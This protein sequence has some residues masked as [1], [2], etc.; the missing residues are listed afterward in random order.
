MGMDVVILSPETEEFL[1][2]LDGLSNNSLIHRNEVSILLE[3]SGRHDRKT[4]LAELAFGAKFCWNL[5]SVMKRIGPGAKGYEHLMSEYN[6]NV[7]KVISS[8]KGLL[9]PSPDEVRKQFEEK[10]FINTQTSLQ[11]QIE[12]F[13]DISWIKNWSIDHKSDTPA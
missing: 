5:F 11:A 12:L 3:L 6:E 9:G 10:F 1:R 7:V 8:L 2:Q 4:Q 13:H